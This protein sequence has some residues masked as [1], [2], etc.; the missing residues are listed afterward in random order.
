MK[1]F[2]KTSRY[3]VVNLF[4]DF[5]LTKIGIDYLSKIEVIDFNSFFLINGVTNSTVKLDM[6]SVR[7]ELCEIFSEYLD[8]YFEK[9]FNVVDL[10]SYDQK[11]EVNNFFQVQ[12]EKPIYQE[13]CSDGFDL[14]FKSSFP[15]GFSYDTGRL[16]Y[17]YYLYIFNQISS[18][19]NSNQMK[20]ELK[21][22]EE[23]LGL[24]I[25]TKSMYETDTIENLILDVFDF[26]L[27]VFREKLENYNILEDIISPDV[28]KPY[29]VQDRLVDII[30]F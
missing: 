15:H 11:I 24:E 17:Y 16:I 9:T 7:D 21:N 13:F 14:S 27:K 19:I 26:D 12:I 29:L 30:I 22:K 18:T 6:G 28:N 1:K 20:I 3:Y 25:Q 2:E 4:A 5:I 8:S 10:L 23:D